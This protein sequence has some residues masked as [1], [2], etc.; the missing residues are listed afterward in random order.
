MTCS[1]SNQLKDHFPLLE[2]KDLH[3]KQ[4]EIT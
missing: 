4:Q 3:N 1:L 2:K